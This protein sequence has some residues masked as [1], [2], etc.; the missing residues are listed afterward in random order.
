MSFTIVPERPQDA[1]LINPLLDRTFGFDRTR[2]TVYRLR[3]HLD[4]LPDLSFSAI[5]DDGGFLASI[6]YWPIAIAGTP[7]ILLGPLAVEPALQGRG[8]GKALVRHSLDAARKGGHRICVVVGEPGY[9]RPFGF[10][11]AAGQGLT[12][13][14]PVEPERFQVMEL[15]PGALAGVYGVIARGEAPVE[16]LSEA[17]PVRRRRVRR[18]VA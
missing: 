17:A 14:G 15:A 2:K 13:P 6:R 11:S 8:I 9:Y 7:A 4:P 3:E 16:P 5:A 1:A 12:L 18:S 10:L